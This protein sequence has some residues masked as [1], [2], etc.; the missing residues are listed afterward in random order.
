MQWSPKRLPI[1]LLSIWISIWINGCFQYTGTVLYNNNKGSQVSDIRFSSWALCIA[2]LSTISLTGCG[3]STS[4]SGEPSS[5]NPDTPSQDNSDDGSDTPDTGTPDNTTPDD[6][7]SDN[8]DTSNPGDNSD[9]DGDSNPPVAPPIG[10]DCQYSVP[11]PPSLT[12]HFSISLDDNTYQHLDDEELVSNNSNIYGTWAV[13]HQQATTDTSNDRQLRRSHQQRAL[14]VIREAAGSTAENPVAEIASCSS[15]GFR[16]LNNPTIGDEFPQPLSQNGDLILSLTSM[17]QMNGIAPHT[18][19]RA[20]KLSDS[21]Q[22]LANVSGTIDGE[23]VAAEDV[24]CLKVFRN[25]QSQQ[26]CAGDVS[27]NQIGSGVG[28]QGESLA[29]TL[30]AINFGDNETLVL[31]SNRPSPGVTLF[32]SE[33]TTAEASALNATVSRSRT[34]IQLNSNLNLEKL[35]GSNFVASDASLVLTTP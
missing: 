13:V 33:L 19:T 32:D 31:E 1:C 35:S 20:I 28:L 15:A 10:S 34:S 26:Q 3:A 5:G 8:P 16:T 6:N 18:N 25:T 11:T 12:E 14:F 24:W 23:S 21:Q 27:Q 2:L 22:P 4:N 29:A 7:N 9:D 17:T 30:Q